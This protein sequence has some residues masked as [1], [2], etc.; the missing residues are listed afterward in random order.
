MPD[1]V[2][3][4]AVAYTLCTVLEFKYKQFN[5]ANTVLVM[6]GSI[7]P[8]LVKVGLIGEYFG[9]GVWNFIWP[10][11]LPAGS[12]IIAG[13]ISLF[14]KDKKNTFLFLSLGVATHYALDMLNYNVSGGMALL[15]PFYWGQWQFHLI[16]TDNIYLPLAALLIA[17]TVYLISRWWTKKQAGKISAD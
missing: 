14:F 17:F 9:L 11:H 7:L 8:D 5:T 15:Y 6:V 16:S 12:L 13:M 1:W 4:I 3:H 2:T 10:I